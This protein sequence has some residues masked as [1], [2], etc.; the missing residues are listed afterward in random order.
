MNE[1]ERNKGAGISNIESFHEMEKKS[2]KFIKKTSRLPIFIN[3]KCYYFIS[4]LV[5]ASRAAS[6]SIPHHI[7]HGTK[8]AFM[9][10]TPF[11]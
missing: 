2:N 8:I 11:S 10:C 1:C 3:I 4:Y 7:K 9:H 6:L 5:F